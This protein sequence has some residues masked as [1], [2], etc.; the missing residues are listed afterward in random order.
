MSPMRVVMKAFFAAAA[1]LG[2]CNPESDQQIGGE[3]DQFPANEEQEQAVRD[4]HAEHRGGEEREISEEAGEIFVRRHVADA[5]DENAKADER[6]HDE[7]GSRQRIEHPA[8]AQRLV[9]ES[10][11]GEIVNGAKAGGL[12]A[13][14]ETRGSRE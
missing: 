2:L 3:P 6:D 9:A 11:P 7:H 12:Q 14:A 4:H 1:A 10:E 13:S 8:E 5:E